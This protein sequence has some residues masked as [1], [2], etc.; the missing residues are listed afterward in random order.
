MKIEYKKAFKQALKKANI[1]NKNLITLFKVFMPSTVKKPLFE[2]LMSG[3][4]GQGSKVNKFENLVGKWIGTKYVVSLNNG[5]S[6]LHLAYRL[7]VEKDGD[8]I[9][10]SPMTCSATN[11]PI[12]NTK[13]T[14]LVWAD[15]DPKT[16][17]IDPEDVKRRIT[18]RTKAIVMVH[19]GGNPCDIEKINAIAKKNNIKT[20]EDAAHSF[21]T[22]YVGKH[23]GSNSSDYV[24]HSLQAIKHINTIDGGLIICK[25]K[26]DYERC[27]LLRWYGIDRDTKKRTDFRCEEDIKEAG[28]KFHMNDISAVIGIDMMNYIDKIVALHRSNAKFYNETLKVDFVHENPDGDSAYWLYTIF[29]R[30]NLIGKFIKY[31]GNNGVQVSRV[32][33]RN[34]THSVF[35]SNRVHLPGVEIFNNCHCCI[36]VG[37]WVGEKEREKIVKLINRY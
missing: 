19:W 30:T 24:V 20:I 18:K 15:V 10:S 25:S 5:T 29:L 27:R 35:K 6:G 11:L 1:E 22:L 26:K 33:T 9:I 12:L 34:D 36:P 32:H 16:G 2:T 7:C 3:Y 4:I 37:W 28:Y 17:S 21:G 8:E 23:L 13:G 31:M 14:K